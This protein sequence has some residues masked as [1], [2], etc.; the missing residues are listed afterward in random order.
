MLFCGSFAGIIIGGGL[1][2]PVGS[3]ASVDGALLAEN[4]DFLMTED[5]NNLATEP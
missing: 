5:G 4:G 3:G 2:F 1:L